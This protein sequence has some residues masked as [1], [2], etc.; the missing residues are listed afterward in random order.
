[1]VYLGRDR[2]YTHRTNFIDKIE[3]GNIFNATL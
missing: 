1:M 2:N 3:V